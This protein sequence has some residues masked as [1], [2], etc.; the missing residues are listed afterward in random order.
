MACAAALAAIAAC[1][2]APAERAAREDPMPERERMI[3]V[4]LEGR[5]IRDPAVLEAMRRV[6]RHEFVPENLRGAAYADHPL[7]IGHGQTISQPYM[8]AAM[9]QLLQP[10]PG[11]RVLEVGTGSGYQ[12]AVLAALV[13]EVYSIEIVEPL[14]R[15]AAA[16]LARLGCTN[17]QVRVGDGYAGW[18]EAAPFDGI[19]VTAAPDHVPA[20]LLVQLKPGGRLVIPVGGP[21]ETQWL[22]VIH[23][24]PDGRLTTERAM[25]VRFVPL[26]GPGAEE[27]RRKP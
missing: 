24:H 2:R 16:R 7:P 18:P 6:P 23:K 10:R 1:G 25:A 3:R 11:H 27:G 19:L 13:K 22:D 4:D 14:G 15:E 8:V 21:G 20:P 17:V 5:D 9:T 26:T 12:A